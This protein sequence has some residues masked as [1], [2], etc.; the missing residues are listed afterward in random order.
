VPGRWPR[1][2]AIGA[3]PHTDGPSST[4]GVG[5]VRPYPLRVTAVEKL[6]PTS[7]PPLTISPLPLPYCRLPS[8]TVRTSP[9]PALYALPRPRLH[10]PEHHR[11]LGYIADLSILANERPSDPSP[12]PH[13]PPS[14]PP[15]RAHTG[16]PPSVEN[17]ISERKI[18]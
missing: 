11:A 14:S 7:T 4:A 16:E 13:L 10:L 9:V 2:R 6:P 12:E 8:S 5:H 3:R 1:A 18:R 17:P 15:L